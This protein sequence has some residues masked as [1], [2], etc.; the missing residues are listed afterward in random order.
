MTS[1][2]NVSPLKIY[3]TRHF[4]PNITP[5]PKISSFLKNSDYILR[6]T[7]DLEED[8]VQKM[9]TRCRMSNACR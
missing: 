1:A 2:F 9:A 5:Q 4:K 8:N 6:P 7:I 3:H